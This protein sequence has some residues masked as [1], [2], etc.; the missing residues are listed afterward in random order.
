ML[1][2]CDGYDIPAYLHPA[3]SGMLADP[4]RWH[5]PALAPLI[6]GVR[7]PDPADVL[8]LDDGA[9]LSLA[10]G[11]DRAARTGPHRGLGDVLPRPRG[12][13]GVA[14]RRRAVRRSVGRV[15]LPGGSWEAM[16]GSLRDVVLPL[17]D[18]TSSSR[19]RSGDDHR[20]GARHEP[21]PRR[22]LGRPEG[23]RAV[24]DLVAPKGTFDVLPPDS[25]RFLAVRDTLTAPLRRAGYGYVETPVF[26]DTAVFARGVG[27][28]TD[29]VSKEMYSFTDK[30]G[31][32]LTLRPEL[33]AGLMRS[34]IEHRLY[35]GPLPVKLW[36]VGSAFRYE[37]P[38]AGATGFTGRRG[39]P[40][41]RRSGA[42]AEVVAL[43]DQGSRDLGL[44]GYELQLT[45]LGDA[46]CRP[47]NRELLTRSW[48]GWTSTR[49]PGAVP[50]STR[51]GCWTTSARRCR[52]SWS[53]RR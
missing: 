44:T 53:T 21:L 51:C 37:R 46:T 50:G 41:D 2:V 33:T 47:R 9:V 14:G 7:L 45:S 19:S 31:R 15:D 30:G 27:E 23:P 4:A 35:A 49:T 29:V 42:D 18:T 43:A 5:G 10:G 11:P 48:R 39:G 22:G 16:L 17:D 40:R 52:R 34:F 8:A 1:P 24:S 32:S 38:Q 13:P 20:A 25:A 6:S 3:D 26:E 12:L 36:S 28:S